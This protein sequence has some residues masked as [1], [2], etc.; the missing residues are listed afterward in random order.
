MSA[1]RLFVTRA[2]SEASP[3]REL[4][5]SYRLS[6]KTLLEFMP[7]SFDT[8][9]QQSDWLF[10]YSKRG[11]AY[12]SDV[13]N[14]LPHQKI[15]CIG[16]QTA[17]Y[18]QDLLGRSVDL[19]GSSDGAATASQLLAQIT[20][21]D[22]VCFLRAKNS[23]KSVQAHLPKNMVMDVVCY[24]NEPQS[25]LSIPLCEV[26]VLT[27]PLNARTWAKAYPGDPTTVTIIAI[28]R[29]TSHALNGMGL[30][31][32]ISDEATEAS[33]ANKIKDLS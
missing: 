17:A 20:S 10:F 28:G 33:I 22:V 4:E 29:S 6:D 23:L 18:C 21:G 7:V 3:L 15:G 30:S 8:S 19:V 9:W 25:N 31:H 24:A 1:P 11:V 13:A 27:S 2:I 5:G 14:P 16:P 32:L 12:F 26:A